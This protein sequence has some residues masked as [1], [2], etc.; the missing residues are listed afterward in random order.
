MILA[1]D[2]D[3]VIHDY[4]NPP[5]GRKMGPPIEGAKEALTEFKRQ[6][7]TVIIHTVWIPET[8][9]TIAKWMEYFDIPYDSITNIK[10]NAACYI[11]DKA[12]HFTAWEN[13]KITPYDND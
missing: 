9:A 1:I 2:Y 13:I 6:G 4:K 3:G 11:D 10:P 7:H 8:H 12:I 5:P